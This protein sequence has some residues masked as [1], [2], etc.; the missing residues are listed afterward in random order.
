MIT[1]LTIKMKQTIKTNYNL[2][3]SLKTWD[4]EMDTC[5]NKE[6]LCFKKSLEYKYI[7]LF[8]IKAD[9]GFDTHCYFSINQ[10]KPRLTGT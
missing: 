3:K 6:E 8:C 9:E 7:Y 2:L 1:Q 10:N 4:E 5:K